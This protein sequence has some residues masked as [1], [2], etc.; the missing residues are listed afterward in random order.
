M[1]GCAEHLALVYGLYCRKSG[2]SLT[3]QAGMSS[4][5]SDQRDLQDWLNYRLLVW[6]L[7]YSMI[8]FLQ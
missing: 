2:I 4:A 1:S 8:R 6:S 3:S 7:G 5:P